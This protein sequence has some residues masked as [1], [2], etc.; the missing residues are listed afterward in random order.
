VSCVLA[1]GTLEIPAVM[2]A[3]TGRR[4]PS[5]EA[6]VPDFAR[7]R[8]RGRVFPGA[9]ESPG[10]TLAGRLYGDVDP[11]TLERLDRFEGALY[12]RRRVSARLAEGGERAAE[13]YLLSERARGELLAEP[14]D[15]DAFVARHLAAWL[16]RCAAFR[17]ED[18]ARAE[19]RGAGAPR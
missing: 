9:V 8:L 17:A 1:Y 18:E 3:V 7:H 11:A 4:F 5:W 2:E 6:S 15:R 13:L 19:A 12:V 16:E 10:G 14:W